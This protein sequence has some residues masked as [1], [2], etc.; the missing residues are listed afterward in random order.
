MK[1]QAEIFATIRSLAR[2]PQ[3]SVLIAQSCY[4]LHCYRGSTYL[5]VQIFRATS[6]PAV[7]SGRHVSH[8]DRFRRRFAQRPITHPLRLDMMDNASALPTC[9][10]RQQQK[11]TAVRNWFKITHT[12]SR[13]SR[14]PCTNQFGAD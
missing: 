11:K 13:R 10:Q 8:L 2:A 6:A 14:K 4:N 7:E 1:T 3:P 9:P 12:T 5:T